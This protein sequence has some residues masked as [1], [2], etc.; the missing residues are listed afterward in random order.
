MIDVISFSYET[1]LPS[2][3]EGGPVHDLRPYKSVVGELDGTEESVQRVLMKDPVFR[4]AIEKIAQEV[5][6]E[7]S[8]LESVA[9]GSTLGKTTSVAAAEIV[10]AALVHLGY[11]VTVTHTAIHKPAKLLRP[12]IATWGYTE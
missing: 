12:T 4:K 11:T 7:A 5:A 3:L 8:D 9:F 6:D 2:N 1:G 10:A